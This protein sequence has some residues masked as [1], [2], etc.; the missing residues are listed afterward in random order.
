MESSGN[1]IDTLIIYCHPWEKSFT[2]A[3]LEAVQRG[4]SRA[5]AA[6]ETIDLYGDGFEPAMSREELS[7]Y[8]EGK[9]EDPLVLRY[10]DLILRS[11]HLVLVFPVWWNDVPAML[12]GFLD[13]VMLPGFSW[14]ATG[15]G[16][17]GKL[18][19]IESVDAYTTSANATSYMQ[20]RLGD[21]I[22]KSLLD[23]TFWQLGCGKGVW[24]NLGSLEAADEE[25]RRRWLEEVERS[26][27]AARTGG[28]GND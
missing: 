3:V 28:N 6:F 24:H 10:Q 5:G 11:R 2:R 22:Q 19:N 15:S 20:E 13:R 18:Q 17:A 8:G 25:E 26:I 7:V 16:I 27:Y 4:L 12:R 1:A 21:G 9:T 23:A 14:E